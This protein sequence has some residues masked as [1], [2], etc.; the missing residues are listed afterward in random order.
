MCKITC[1]TPC[2]LHSHLEHSFINKN[3]LFQQFS[4]AESPLDAGR[5]ILD[6]FYFHFRRNYR[7]ITVSLLSVL[8][9]NSLYDI[10]EIHQT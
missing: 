6:I 2:I 7:I 10:N 5:V 1:I 8:E 3:S 4:K 9:K